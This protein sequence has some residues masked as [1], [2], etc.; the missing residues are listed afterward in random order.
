MSSD[1]K[2]RI[3]QAQCIGNVEP[4]E[5]MVPYPNLRSLVDG[6]NIKYGEKMV[7]AD[8]NLTSDKI[9]RLA[10]QTANWLVAEGI[11]PKDRILIDKLPFPQ[12]EILAFGIWTLGASMVI[13]GDGDLVGAKKTISPAIV[14]SAE[15]DYFKKIKS[16]P[17]N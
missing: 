9:Y 11:K 13:T 16:F 12:T 4:I 14:I 5:H 3:Y 17:E 7:Y 2:K 1:L 6:Q 15:T 8:L 10:Q